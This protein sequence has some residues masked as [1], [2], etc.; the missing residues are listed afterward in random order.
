MPSH[1][2]SRP[3]S[4]T[5]NATPLILCFVVTV[6]HFLY[7]QVSR[8][9]P[10]NS[11]SRPT[12]PK[13]LILYFAQTVTH[14]LYVSGV[15]RAALPLDQPSHQPQTLDFILCDNSYT[16]F[17]FFNEPESCPA[18]FPAVPPARCPT[19]SLIPA[20]RPSVS[21]GRQLSKQPGRQPSNRFTVYAGFLPGSPVNQP[22]RVKGRIWSLNVAPDGGR[23]PKS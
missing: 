15:Q 13:H 4:Q 21:P 22:L 11:A 23:K 10:S 2:P 18:T 20:T 6:T 1:L 5:R 14:F 17:I 16:L 7:F 12:S 19:P 3:T 9:P 8:K